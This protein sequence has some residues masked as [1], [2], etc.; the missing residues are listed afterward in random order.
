MNRVLKSLAAG[1]CAAFAAQV[2]GA[3]PM[4]VRSDGIEFPD[5]T[6]QTTAT[7]AGVVANPQHC[8]HPSTV[9]AGETL[10]L[11]CYSYHPGGGAWGASGVPDGLYFV[12]T[13]VLLAPDTLTVDTGDVGFTL[14]HS[15]D[16]QDASPGNRLSHRFRVVPNLQTTQWNFRAPLMLLI[17]GDCLRVTGSSGITVPIV[18]TVTGFLTANPERLGS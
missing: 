4:S 12:V 6:V 9:T 14:W 17:P 16:C 2:V 3:T 13:D 5:G 15:Y 7:A 10:P 8:Y 18:I 11:T 1:A